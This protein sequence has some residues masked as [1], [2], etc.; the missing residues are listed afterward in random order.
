VRLPARAGNEGD[1]AL[2]VPAIFLD[3]D[4]VVNEN[5]TDH[6]KG[7]DEFRFL[8]GVFE[9]LRLL[10][11]IGAPIF[12]VTNQAVVNRNLLSRDALEDI[13]LKMLHLLRAAG[14]RVEAVLSCPHDAG[15]RCRCRKPE[16]GLLLSAARTHGIDLARSVLVGDALTDVLAGKRAGCR[17]VLVLTGRGRD[18]LDALH[19]DPAT[20]PDAIARDLLSAAAFVRRFFDDAGGE[21]EPHSM[22]RVLVPAAI[23]SPMTGALAP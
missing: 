12:V 20:I 10:T 13:H 19:Q 5:R 18:A 2:S 21:R 6:V 17:T 23:D 4:G 15:E 11:D 22:E 7:W 8:P 1:H 16:P 9:A 3:R 14:G